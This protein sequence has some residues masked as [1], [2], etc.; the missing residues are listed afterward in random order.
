M[1]IVMKVSFF[2]SAWHQSLV[3]CTLHVA[4]LFLW[5]VPLASAICFINCQFHVS[6]IPWARS[7]N[8]SG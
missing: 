1:Q 4:V 3:A 2:I 7:V 5:T 8:D 6:F